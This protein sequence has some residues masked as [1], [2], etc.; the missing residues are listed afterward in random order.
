[1]NPITNLQDEHRELAG[2][3]LDL[4]NLIQGFH[5][6]DQA[7]SIT[8]KLGQLAHLLR[9]HLA[10]EDEWFYPAMIASDEP[11]AATLAA[12][13]REEVGGIAEQVEA[14]T[15]QWNSSSVIGMG[16]RRF[17]GE[18][19]CLLHKIEDRIGREDLELYPIAR[20]LGIG[21]PAAAA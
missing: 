3:M 19:L 4:V 12:T 17:R 5:G 9:I 7:Y 1:M 16:F 14:F 8:V 6:P 21:C 10:T 20:A 13:Y 11:L 2:M 18:L 15:A